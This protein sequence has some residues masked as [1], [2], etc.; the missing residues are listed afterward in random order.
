MESQLCKIIFYYLV[1]HNL[2][3]IHLPLYQAGRFI[4]CFYEYISMVSKATSHFIRNNFRQ[5]RYMRDYSHSFQGKKSSL[6]SLLKQEVF[7]TYL[8]LNL[9]LNYL[10]IMDLIYLGPPCLPERSTKSLKE[11]FSWCANHSP[12]TYYGFAIYMV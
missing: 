12:D 8:L 11:C 5:S 4:Q 2:Y 7:D 3:I 10:K 9:P 6:C 1:F